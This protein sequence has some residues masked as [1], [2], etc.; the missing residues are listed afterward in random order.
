MRDAFL[1][2]AVAGEADDVVVENLVHSR[3]EAR[4][5]HLLR[6]RDTDRV[7]DALPERTGGAFD[8]VGFV[9][10]RMPRRLRAQS[11]GSSSSGRSSSTR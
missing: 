9:R 10:L 1:Q 5:G 3:V 4:R 6:D 11:N 8:A 2:A 7:G